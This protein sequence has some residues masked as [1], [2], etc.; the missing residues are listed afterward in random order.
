MTAANAS[1]NLEGGA[2][3]VE[4]TMQAFKLAHEACAAAARG[5]A[6]GRKDSLARVRDAERELDG[7]DRDVDDLVTATIAY[8]GESQVRELLACMKFVI[9]LERIGDLLLSFT[10]H[11]DSVATRI[12]R[13]DVLDLTSMASRVE[14]MV[15]KVEESFREKSLDA[16]VNVLRSDA[17]IDR[18][19]NMVVFRQL[20]PATDNINRESFHVVAMAQDLERAG[21]HAK[22]MAEEVCHLISGHTVRHVLRSYDRPVEQLFIDHLRQRKEP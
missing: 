16:A 13:Q 3:V 11:A 10:N 17:E 19:R 5:I 12:G 20:E 2:H 14:Q 1:N 8:T 18:L 6:T 22:S 7:L 4:L 21:D 15:L 9:A